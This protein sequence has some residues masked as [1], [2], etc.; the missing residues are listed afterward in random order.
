MN[1]NENQCIKFNIASTED[2]IN[3]RCIEQMQKLL[4]NCNHPIT[5]SLSRKDTNS[6][7]NKFEFNIERCKTERHM[8][9]FV[10]K[11]L[12]VLEKTGFVTEEKKTKET[13]TNSTTSKVI[14]NTQ[15]AKNK[16][17]C[18]SCH[19]FFITG[20][21]IATHIRSCQSKVGS[22]STNTASAQNK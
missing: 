16:T 10:P 6:T 19:K 8:N 5:N 1:I 9:T 17:A 22:T 15:A 2:L 21:G 20:T 7:R 12:R 13:N 3:K 18:P 11:Y 4:N 14:Q